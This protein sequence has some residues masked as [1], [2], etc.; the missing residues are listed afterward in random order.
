M[1]RQRR[2]GCRIELLVTCEHGGNLV[3]DEYRELFRDAESALHSHRGFDAGALDVARALA[4]RLGARLIFAE[5]TRLLVD[6]NR[7]PHHPKLFSEFS[8]RLGADARR[9]LLAGHYLPY[10]SEVEQAVA[11]AAAGAALVLHV[12]SHTFTPVLG[13]VVRKADVALLFDPSRALEKRMAAL[14][15]EA[16][17]AA[18]PSWSV[19]RNYPYRG[20]ADGLTA[21]LRRRFPPRRYAGLELEVNQGLATDPAWPAHA[22]LIA[23]AGWSAL[24]SF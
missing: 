19:R 22:A 3:P 8:R 17:C 18:A 1:M 15:R 7:S 14:W 6:L 16:L 2:N 23:A 10:R 5:T 24:G 12:S 4:G 11:E 13:D 20:S 9:Q 21:H